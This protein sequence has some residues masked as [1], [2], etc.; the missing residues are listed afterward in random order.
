M[1][2]INLERHHALQSAHNVQE[3][4]SPALKLLG[5][6]YFNYIKVYND[7]CSRELLASHAPWI[8][9][10]Y[11]NALFQSACIVDIEHLL[12]KGFYL[13]TELDKKDPAYFQGRDFNIDNGI[14]FV[15]KTA[16]ATYIYIFASTP[17][18]Y[19]MNNFYIA[20]IDLLQ[21]FIHY[22]NDKAKPLIDEASKNRII[23]PE[24]QSI[25]PNK[26]N[27]LSLSDKARGQFL[28]ETKVERYF[29]FN[30]S[31][32]LYLTRKQGLCASLLVKGY[33]SKQIAKEVNISHRTVEGYFL[34]MKNKME[35]SL[36]R[37][38]SKNQIIQIL[39]QAQIC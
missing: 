9:H 15:S 5:V 38:L 16:K 35:E 21:R 4:C 33:T 6:S 8:K 2:G 37:T 23:L 1:K 17:A 26:I 30:E 12:P 3:I 28:E 22:F 19:G 7:D 39:Q 13:W 10:F 27:Y 18:Q 34:K 14:S 36:K 25:S 31:Q 24:Q 20:N 29:L 11:E 32:D